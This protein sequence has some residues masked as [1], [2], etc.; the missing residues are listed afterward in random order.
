MTNAEFSNEFDTLFNNI[1]SNQAPGIDEYEK[2]VFLTQ[3]QDQIVKSYFDPKLNK[4]QEGFDGNERRQIDFSMLMRTVLGTVLNNQNQVNIH[5]STNAKYYGMP[6]DILLY[7]NEVL[8]VLRKGITTNLVVV[9]VSYTDYNRLM[10][11]PFKRP[12]KNQ[13][14]RLI[15][16]GLS[17]A[18]KY[19]DYA[20]IASTIAE[21]W[22]ASIDGI[23]AL[24]NNKQ[25]TVSSGNTIE[26]WLKVDNSYL[27]LDDDGSP[28]LD[29]TGKDLG[30]I[31]ATIT[32]YCNSSV[33]ASSTIVELIP[34]PQDTITSY[35]IR[36][37]ARP[38]PIILTDLTDEGVTLGGGK[39]KEQACE[40]D[41]IIHHEILERAVELAKAA[42]AGTLQDTITLGQTSGTPIG[43][44]T[45]N[46]RQ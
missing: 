37:V 40:L 1:T 17:S 29:S 18:F 4:P 9:P 14:W 46:N 24:I 39:V 5:T 35:T 25:L 30:S 2:S 10:S 11:K 43:V 36:Y 8:T 20:K 34:G 6:S 26:Y 31:Y 16:S 22:N 42:Y 33:A 27:T 23:Y 38:K 32:S 12:L 41:P 28:S 13:A 45:N 7:I 3:A 19:T 44:V 21:S 15:T